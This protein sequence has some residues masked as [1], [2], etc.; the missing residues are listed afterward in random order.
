M[1]K[2]NSTTAVDSLW[3]QRARRVASANKRKSFLKLFEMSGLDKATDFRFADWSGINFSK[4]DLTGFDF[5]GA[6][7]HDCNF[8]GAK[9]SGAR[10]DQAEIGAV[11]HDGKANPRDPARQT[12]FAN[13]CEAADWATCFDP[14]R[15]RKRSAPLSAGH[16]LVGAVFQDAPFAPEMVVVPAG[17]FAMGSPHGSDG[18]QDDPHKEKFYSGPRQTITFERPF[19]IGRFVVKGNEFIAFEQL[20]RHKMHY[21][22]PGMRP[23]PLKLSRQSP[24]INVRWYEAVTYCDWLN[25]TLGLPAGTYRLP[26]EAEWEYAA[27]AGTDGPFW[28]EGPISID[29]ANYDE[30]KLPLSEVMRQVRLRGVV[31]VD[32]FSPNPWGLY[33]VHGNVWEWCQDEYHES[34]AGIPLDGTARDTKYPSSTTYRVNRGGAWHN[35]P[36]HL[37]VHY[38]GDRMASDHDRDLGFRVARTLAL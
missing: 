27:R 1:S 6:R 17:K 32:R 24:V 3:A 36:L 29:K 11:L 8:K 34:L 37:Q 18:D 23:D 16:L 19:A 2:D 13:L 5:T 12:K 31:P 10:F 21:P 33:Q 20:N 28:W 9:I 26:S 4:S 25:E 38:R 22:A 15:W 7:L 30:N 35:T 14:R